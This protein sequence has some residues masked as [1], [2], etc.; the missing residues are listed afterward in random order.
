MAIRFG[1]V[2]ELFDLSGRGLVVVTDTAY[3]QLPGDL[4]V[5]IGS[6]VE[7]RHAGNSFEAEVKGIEHCDPW[8][9]RHKFAFLLSSDISKNQI[10]IGAD[11]WSN[12]PP[13]VITPTH[14]N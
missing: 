9:E 13:A 3:E 5:T 1:K 14:K 10:P 4:A 8:T 12:A 7:F 6:V 2:E 11:I